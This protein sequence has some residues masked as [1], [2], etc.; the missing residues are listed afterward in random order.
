MIVQISRKRY[1]FTQE[2]NYMFGCVKEYPTNSNNLI[3]DNITTITT[4]GIFS[5]VEDIF[6]EELYS[7]FTC[8]DELCNSALIWNDRICTVD[9]KVKK[10]NIMSKCGVSFYINISNKK[11]FIYLILYF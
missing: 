2:W 9:N 6:G 4:D 11:Y 3:N 5:V 1:S 7:V 8:K 10:C